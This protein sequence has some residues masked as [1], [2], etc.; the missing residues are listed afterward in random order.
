MIPIIGPR[1]VEQLDNNLWALDL[2]F[3]DELY[4]RLD[5]LS[6]ISPGVPFAVNQETLQ[7][8]LGGDMLRV[9]LPITKAL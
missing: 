9:D 2:V 7:K 4:D 1:T 5:K 8:L 6:A 3:P